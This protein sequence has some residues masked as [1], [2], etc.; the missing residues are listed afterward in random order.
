MP[1]DFYICLWAFFLLSVMNCLT[2]QNLFVNLHQIGSKFF[3][4]KVV[5]ISVA[6]L[7]HLLL[8]RP[9]VPNSYQ[10]LSKGAV[11]IGRNINRIRT[12][13]L[14]ETRASTSHHRHSAVKSLEQRN[15]K[16]LDTRW[17]TK[18]RCH[19]I[20]CRQMVERHTMNHLHT[21]FQ[22]LATQIFLNLGGI[23]CTLA[24]S[25]NPY[26]VGHQSE[27]LGKKHQILSLL[28]AAN[29]QNVLVRQRISLAH[30]TELALGLTLRKSLVASLINHGT[31]STPCGG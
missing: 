15:T 3:V 19:L 16:A 7:N 25:H 9:V 26:M 4:G 28:N 12:S 11:V 5:C 1:K 17:I 24:N 21:L 31:K 13:S 27:S 2:I 29:V 8:Q 23:R 20:N 18:H 14:F 22:P 30:L 10:I 6:S